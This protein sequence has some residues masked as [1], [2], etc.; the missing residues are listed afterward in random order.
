[1][2]IEMRRTPPF[3]VKIKRLK[4]KSI[5]LQTAVDISRCTAFFY[6]VLWGILIACYFCIIQ[7]SS[8]TRDPSSPAAAGIMVIKCHNYGFL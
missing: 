1:M 3:Q 2:L 8:S 5:P 4:S 6:R 7:C